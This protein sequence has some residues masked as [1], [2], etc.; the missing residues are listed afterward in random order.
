M[1][2]TPDQQLIFKLQ[3]IV[4]LD[5]G[6]Q[7]GLLIALVAGLIVFL[8]W[9]NRRD[10]V[11]QSPAIRGLLLSLRL[12]AITTI[13]IWLLNPVRAS[14]TH[15]LKVSRLAVLVDTSLSMGIADEA[16]APGTSAQKDSRLDQ[17]VRWIEQT[18]L[19]NELQRSHELVVYRFDE[20]A[21]PE[22]I[23]TFGR[24]K[25]VNADDTL[26]PASKLAREQWRVGVSR[27]VGI[28]GVVVAILGIALLTYWITRWTGGNVP[29]PI[30]AVGGLA[31]V[32]V[33]AVLL[34]ISDVTT[35]QKSLWQS[36]GW[37]PVK[38][39][40]QV[41][42]LE[43]TVD[44][45][46][47]ELALAD[48][49]WA[50]ELSARGT[51]TRMGSAI[52]TIVNR[53]RSGPIAGVMLITDGRSNDGA[54][55]DNAMAAAANAGIPFFPVGIGSTKDRRN[56]FVH[57]LRSPTTV[58]PGDRFQ[59]SG[60]VTA[61]ALAGQR[62]VVQLRS[63]EDGNVDVSR[64]EGE[65][66]IEL[67][68]DGQPVPFQFEL[69]ESSEGTRQFTAEV[70]MAQPD[71]DDRDNARSVTINFVQR[72]TKVLL[73]AGGPTREFRFLRN[74]LFRDENMLL[75]VWLQSA[76]PGADQESD[77]LLE[78]FPQT[79][80]EM[81]QYDCVIAFDPDWQQLSS[82]QARLLEQWVSRQA[83]GMVVIAGPVNTPHWTRQ[84]RGDETIDAIRDLYPVSF[85]AQG[86]AMTRLGR[87]GG[88]EAFPLQFT[89]VGRTVNY[90][91]LGDSS[92]SS[93]L[94]WDQFE[95]VFGYYAVNES[96]P[97]ADVLARF[98]DPDTLVNE[99]LPIYLA[100]QYY[101]AGRVFFQA[102][103]E[104]WRVRR[105]DVTYFQRYYTQL[106]RW[107]SQGRLNRDSTRGV[108]LVDRQTCWVGDPVNVQAI[109]QDVRDEPLVAPVVDATITR[110]DESLQ[111]LTLRPVNDAV[112]PGSFSA[113]FFAN[114]E[115]DY[116]VQ[117]PVPDSA[118]LE[119]LTATV[120]ARIPDLEKEKPQRNDE[121]LNR[122]AE[123]TGGHYFVGLS[124]LDVPANDP[125]SPMNLIQSRDQESWLEG[126]PD[127]WFKRKLMMWLLGF[128]VSLQCVA[129]T[130][131]RLNRLA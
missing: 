29:P 131:R 94:T 7:I 129:W 98:A 77:R 112:T 124:E 72:Q 67:S 16:G 69:E 93:Q 123:Q 66:E 22:L 12:L 9:L 120:T 19:L 25:E 85:Y 83:G 130:V 65:I 99:Q 53:E 23:G 32:L 36:L 97:G 101:G 68:D 127:R 109:L 70:V 48:V 90:L 78:S 43:T 114:R 73:M 51:T 102:S 42:E 125:L 33:A 110:P 126:T 6:W 20:T 76:Q 27:Q 92:G 24:Q 31:I 103:G 119:V 8:V 26:L 52:E 108:L 5:E 59:L 104:M 47:D 49:D 105:M 122:I 11:N 45:A 62:A 96:K 111:E 87:F 71:D 116:F 63:F 60:L 35:P 37:V 84:P 34:C 89:R 21:T 128:F 4:P 50:T 46:A 86:S 1:P 121:L 57:D 118:D 82:E 88:S 75:D 91:W 55:P 74:Q 61:S 14:R 79:R 28:A 3:P 15:L 56:A 17:V 58:L 80:D 113:Q 41:D 54:E 106:I 40:F 64:D 107:A 30:I 2:T 95:G 81:Y 39:S 44:P 100:S 117:L 10:T 115:G 18:D 13:V 38:E